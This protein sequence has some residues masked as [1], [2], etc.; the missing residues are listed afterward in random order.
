MTRRAP[1]PASSP[2]SVI[3]ERGAT[4]RLAQ[5]FQALVPEIDRQRQLLALAEQEVAASELGQDERLRG[6]LEQRRDDADVV[7]GRAA[8]CRPSTR[9]SSRRRARPRRRR[10]SHQRRPAGADR[11]LARD[12]GRYGAAQSRSSAAARS[13]AHR[14]GRAPLARRRRDRRRPTPTISC[15]S[16]TS[17]RPGAWP[18]R[19]STEAQRRRRA[20][21]RAAALERFGHGA[22]MKHVGKHLRSADD[23]ELTSASSGCAT[24]SARRSSRRSPKCCR[25]SRTRD[26]GGGC[27]ISWW[28]SARPAASRCSS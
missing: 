21:R 8:S 25:R 6:A 20:G 10:R 19:S 4:D 17:I 2:D 23:D 22:M 1:S 15:A 28:G 27:A 5:A 13:A 9:A 3:S 16:A 12:R 18:M 14:G 11:D 7:L 26:R 24:R